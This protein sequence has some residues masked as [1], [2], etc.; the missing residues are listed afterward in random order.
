M[1]PERWQRIEEIFRTVVDRPASEREAYLTRACGGDEDLRLEVLSLLERDTSEEFIRDRIASVAVSFTAKSKNDLTGERIGPY[2]VT[3]LIGRGGMGAVYEAERD[4]EQF[5]RQVAIKI[6]KR[7]MDTDFVRDRFLRERQI[8]ASLDHPRIARLFDGGTAQDGSPYFVMEFVAG[9]PITT[10]CR[11][12]QLSVSERL[13]LFRKVCSAVQ[14]AHQRLVIHRDLKPSNILIAEDGEPKLLDFG[15]AK[16]L[17]PDVSQ[18]HTRTETAL[19]LMTPEYASPEQARGQAVATTTDVYSLGVVLYELLTERRPHEFKTYSPAE[20]ERAIC[21]TEI[22]EPSK[23]VSR[24]T[25]APS[26]LAR[27]LAGDLDNI[28]LMAM[29]KE[30]ERRYQS[31]EQFSEDIR[32]HLEGLPVVARKDTFGY[33]AGKFIRRQ[34]AGVSILALL[35]ILAVAMAVQSVRIAKERD[36]ANQEAATA[37]AVTQSLV[38]MF[39]FADP[40]K[41][42]GGAITA[43]ELLD[44]GAEKVVRELKDQPVVQA[45]LLDTIGRLYQSIGLY[46]REKPLLEEALKL[47]RQALGDEHPDVATSLDHLGE[48]ASLKGD[49]AGSES[50]FREALAMRRKLFGA[51]NKDVAESLNNLGALLVE[52]GSFGEAEGLLRE[53][54]VLR[55]KLF[56]EEH[57]EVAD[58]L[59]SL[60][61]LMSYSGKFNEAESLYR[62][63]LTIRRNLYGGDHPSVASSMNRLAAMLHEL[64]DLDGAKAMFRETLALRRKLLDEEHTDVASSM[65]NL[66]SVLQDTKEYDEAEQLYRRTLAMRR[67]LFGEEHPSLAIT[68]NNLATLL[69]D[70]GSY[71]EA[72]AL[73]QQSLAMRRKQFGNE[74]QEVG[75]ALHN[76][77]SLFYLKGEYDASEKIER[78]AIGVYQKSLKPDHWVIHQSRRELGGSL[79]KLKRYREAEEELL[80]AHS[81]LKAALGDQH[82]RTQRAIRYLVELYESWGKPRQAEAY[83]ALLQTKEKTS[84]PSKNP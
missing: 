43:R 2:R 25:G 40:G 71:E 64:G 29:R 23:A 13:R 50:L 21:D 36:R 60:G 62:Q 58:S 51:G 83:S 3:R 41:A 16:L 57:E 24:T 32:R 6:I 47:R 78:Q 63:A 46:D 81:G 22:E 20:I 34:K 38:A 27:Q 45:K 80:A 56:G 84:P 82:E 10:Y 37:Q 73:F 75:I 28:T 14:H 26:R 42:R 74:H 70:K 8:L 19:R 15:I 31:V 49:F 65:A 72:G 52:R 9:E 39:E 4:D 44:Q 5:R 69:R 12:H 11:R 76:V 59:T 67:K 33:R 61:R 7:G 1:N 53:A 54:L 18:A 35:M 17:S 68:I 79:I 30:P 48:V 66:A 77:A 55:R